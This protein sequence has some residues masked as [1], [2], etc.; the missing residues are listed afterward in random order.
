MKDI[1]Q[2]DLIYAFTGTPLDHE[3]TPDTAALLHRLEIGLTSL[4]EAQATQDK[5]L[6]VTVANVLRGSLIRFSQVYND[7][8]VAAKVDEL[9]GLTSQVTGL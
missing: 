1:T 7:P 3:K 5:R 2:R 6:A 9:I 8:E 4:K